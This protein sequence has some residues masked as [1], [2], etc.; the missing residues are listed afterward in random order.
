MIK[1]QDLKVRCIKEAA[2]A[3]GLSTGEMFRLVKSSSCIFDAEAGRV[4]I[5]PESEAY[6]TQELLKAKKGGIS[7]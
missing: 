5:D 2:R 3:F 6:L 7:A 4:I 1:L